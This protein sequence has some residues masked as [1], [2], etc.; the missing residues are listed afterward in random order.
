MKR[1]CNI[2]HFPF[3]DTE[4]SACQKMIALRRL[5][6]YKNTAELCNTK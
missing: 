5:S 6:I 2:G 1:T 4:D 3:L